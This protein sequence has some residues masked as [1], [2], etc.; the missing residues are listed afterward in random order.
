MR[1]KVQLSTAREI[2]PMVLPARQD[3]GCEH[4]AP[5]SGWLPGEAAADQLLGSPQ[6]GQCETPTRSSTGDPTAQGEVLTHW[7]PS[8]QRHQLHT[9]WPFCKEEELRLL[10]MPGSE[11]LGFELRGPRRGGGADSESGVWRRGPLDPGSGTWKGGK[12]VELRA[13]PLRTHE[14]CE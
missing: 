8:W 11:G 14:K 1:P 9:I 12:V 3:R 13:W 7:L 6:Q 4:G 2:G 5:S 10:E